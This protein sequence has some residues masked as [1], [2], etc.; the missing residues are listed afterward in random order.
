MRTSKKT[1]EALRIKDDTEYY[2]KDVVFLVEAT[3][4]EQHYLWLTHHFKDVGY[5]KVE[6]WEQEG[7][8]HGVI[9]GYVDKRPVNLSISYAKIDG[10]RVAF[11]EGVSQVVDHEMIREWLRP[12]TKHLSWDGGRIARCDAMNFA[13]CLHAIEAM[14][15]R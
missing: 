6:R 10:R 13:H 5:G 2:F 1:V 14:N 9:I 11:F 8:G 7:M 4:C 15:R 3:H 12:R